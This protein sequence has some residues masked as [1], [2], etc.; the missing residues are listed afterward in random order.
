M[1][2]FV[3]F[4]P[5]VV[6]RPCYSTIHNIALHTETRTVCAR[7]RTRHPSSSVSLENNNFH[8]F[9]NGNNI[10]SKH[11]GDNIYVYYESGQQR[12]CIYSGICVRVP[13][14]LLT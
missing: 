3:D 10:N 13:R 2:I 9:R 4:F 6:V 8:S 11:T 5:V 14:V 12:Q 1:I 7:Q